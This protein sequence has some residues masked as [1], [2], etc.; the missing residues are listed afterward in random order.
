MEKAIKII[1]FV[2]AIVVGLAAVAGNAVELSKEIN[3]AN[4]E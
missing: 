1:G 2:G 4:E 3:D